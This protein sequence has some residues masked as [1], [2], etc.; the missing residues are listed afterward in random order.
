M[1]PSGDRPRGHLSELVR[2]VP[3]ARDDEGTRVHFTSIV[4][5]PGDD[6]ERIPTHDATSTPVRAYRGP[7]G[8]RVRTSGAWRALCAVPAVAGE[9]RAE[10]LVRVDASVAQPSA[11]PSHRQQG[12]PKLT[13]E[14]STAGSFG[15]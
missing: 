12:V 5:M 11:Q 10:E 4:S 3:A 2:R 1:N 14:T 6:P 8:E 15:R 7:N 13:V 9:V